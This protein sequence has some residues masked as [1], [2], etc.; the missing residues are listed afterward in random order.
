M[1][2]GDVGRWE[3][4]SP[5]VAK[6]GLSRFPTCWVALQH[7]CVAV[8]IHAGQHRLPEAEALM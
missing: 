3:V 7:G 4:A 1:N 8:F 2:K 5:S 6:L